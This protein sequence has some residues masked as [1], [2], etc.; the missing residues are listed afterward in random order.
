MALRLDDFRSPTW[1]RLVTHVEGR[2]AELRVLND[3][4]LAVERTAST[5]GGIAELKRIL[6]LADQASAEPAVVP[7]EL[8]GDGVQE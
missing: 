2:I 3:Q 6:A 4:P 7:G 1:K 5:R 8:V